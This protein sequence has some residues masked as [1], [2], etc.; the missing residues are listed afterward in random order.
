MGAV[1]SLDLME[2]RQQKAIDGVEKWKNITNFVFYN[3]NSGHR[4][5][6]GFEGEESPYTAIPEE[7]WAEGYLRG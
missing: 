6:T 2:S 4:V 3:K 5:E 1:L 7:I